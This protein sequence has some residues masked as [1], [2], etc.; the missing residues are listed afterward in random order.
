MTLP[1]SAA[2]FAVAFLLTWLLVIA[3][4]DLIGSF[5]IPYLITTAFFVLLGHV[6]SARWAVEI[7]YAVAPGSKRTAAVLIATSLTLF[8]F[9]GVV[10]F[11]NSVDG[12]DDPGIT[13]FMGSHGGLWRYWLIFCN[14]A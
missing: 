10:L 14:V 5:L 11:W 7:A 6:Y 12:G 13:F 1:A 8:T 9:S 4:F 2:T 3:S